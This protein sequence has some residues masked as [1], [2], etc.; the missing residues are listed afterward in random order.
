MR[1]RDDIS[2]LFATWN[3]ALQ[4]GDPDV[5]VALY[6]PD[7]VLLPTF[8]DRVRRTPAQI[9]DYFV[10][11]LERRPSASIDAA[12]CRVYGDV[13]IHSGI[14][15][16]RFAAG[17]VRSAQARFTFVYRCVG[18]GWRIVEH[19]SSAMPEQAATARPGERRATAPDQ[20][21]NSMT[22]L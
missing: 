10:P 6:A 22:K 11:F 8:S 3:A 20:A 5:V 7:A 2:E 13:A 21:W 19:H 16:F 1:L 4:T 15:S 12:S 14:Y 9:R 18:D 17:P